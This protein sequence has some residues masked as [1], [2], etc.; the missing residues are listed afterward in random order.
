M[1]GALHAAAKRHLALVWQRRPSAVV[2]STPWLV[3]ITAYSWPIS[4][5]EV[6]MTRHWKP[7]C[8]P[9]CWLKSWRV[10]LC[11]RRQRPFRHIDITVACRLQVAGCRLQQ[12]QRKQTWTVVSLQLSARVFSM[13]GFPACCVGVFSDSQRTD[14][15]L[16]V[17]GCG[18]RCVS[19]ARSPKRCAYSMACS[20][21]GC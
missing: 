19:L 15:M 20:V 13:A 3:R 12:T 18:L 2:V 16:A 9:P 11:V 17:D 1:S 5:K 7:P 6:L 4:L 21:Y 10:A 8:I 14:V